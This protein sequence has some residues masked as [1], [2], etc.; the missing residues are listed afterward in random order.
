MQ[1]PESIKFNLVC[2]YYFLLQMFTEYIQLGSPKI[3]CL[4]T[5]LEAGEYCCSVKFKRCSQRI[6]IMVDEDE[7]KSTYDL[8]Q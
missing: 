2:K 4:P 5:D 6:D 3:D 7:E 1:I 8:M